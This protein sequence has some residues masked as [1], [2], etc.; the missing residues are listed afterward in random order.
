MPA[1]VSTRVY[2]PFYTIVALCNLKSAGIRKR[3]VLSLDTPQR[4]KRWLCMLD[5]VSLLCSMKAHKCEPCITASPETKPTEHSIDNIALPPVGSNVVSI[6]RLKTNSHNPKVCCFYGIVAP[7]PSGPQ[8]AKVAVCVHY[9][10]THSPKE[11]YSKEYMTLAE[12]TTRQV[13]HI[14]QEFI[15]QIKKDGVCIT[16]NTVILCDVA[17]QSH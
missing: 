8:Y 9:H 10:C 15:G 16:A 6:N 17:L 11:V 5:P 2:V 3:Q 13:K 1:R 7:V 14:P 4:S 12:F